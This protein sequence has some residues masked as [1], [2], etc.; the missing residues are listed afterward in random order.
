MH[1]EITVLTTKDFARLSTNLWGSLL[2]ENRNVGIG[3]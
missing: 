3:V 2:D 1:L